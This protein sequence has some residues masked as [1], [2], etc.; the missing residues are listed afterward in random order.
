MEQLCFCQRD[1]LDISISVFFYFS[2]IGLRYSKSY[3]S[4]ADP[5]FLEMGFVC[6]EMWVSFC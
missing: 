3:Y 5:G 1:G 2:G 4:G 6:L